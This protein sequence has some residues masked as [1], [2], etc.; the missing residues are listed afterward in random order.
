MLA[1]S[2]LSS[3]EL[4]KWVCDYWEEGRGWKW[5]SFDH[6]LPPKTLQMIVSFELI[7][8]DEFQ[9]QF[10]WRASS[11]GTFTIKSA[12]SIIRKDVALER[13]DHWLQL[14][15]TKVPQRIKVF[16]WLL[17]QDS[18]MLNST[19]LKQDLTDNP[20]CVLCANEYEDRDHIFRQCPKATFIC[21]SFAHRNLGRKGSSDDFLS[22]FL[23]NLQ[24]MEHVESWPSQFLIILWYIW[25][26]RNYSCFA[27]E[28]RIPHDR[29]RFLQIRC[30]DIL[31]ALSKELQVD[32]NG[33]PARRETLISW[34]PP[35][36]A[37][38]MEGVEHRWGV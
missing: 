37:G 17:L 19:R 28:E 35:P 3:E 34:Q 15:K 20:F 14:W 31:Q 12:L 1:H 18:L 33:R 25:T 13:G 16:T 30:N 23:V 36:A 29:F 26:W 11:S 5:A 7:P 10:F 8:V 21:R 24:D 32:G 22:W 6:L 4:S 27:K 2:S 9:D 38:W